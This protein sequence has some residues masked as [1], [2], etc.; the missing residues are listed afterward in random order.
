MK[1]VPNNACRNYV[2]NRVPF[3]GSH[4][5]GES[6]D[7]GARYPAYIVCSYGQHWPLYIFEGRGAW[8]R[9]ITK[10]SVSTSKHSTQA[11]PTYAE[12]A[13]VTLSE[14]RAMQARILQAA[15]AIRN[16]NLDTSGDA[17]VDELL[18]PAM[19]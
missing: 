15:R 18:E 19:A 9:N 8:Y 10:R 14:A 12:C 11:Y 1:R 7:I 17:S 6:M 3:M 16:R 13:G 2:A 4:L 5:F